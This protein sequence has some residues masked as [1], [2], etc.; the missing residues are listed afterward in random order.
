M[1]MSMCF[2]KGNFRFLQ[3]VGILNGILGVHVSFLMCYEI[4]ISAIFTKKNLPRGEDLKNEKKT[5]CKGYI[6]DHTT[7][8]YGIM[9]NHCKLWGSLSNNQY[10]G[11]QYVFC[12]W[13]M[14]FSRNHSTP[15][16]IY[17]ERH[18]LL[19]NHTKNPQED[20]RACC[21]LPRNS[22]PKNDNRTFLL[23]TC[24]NSTF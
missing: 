22:R 4:Y 21:M 18:Q 1:L 7:Q 11:K 12:C 13:L 19:Q 2:F 15:C 20:I 14:C 10:H 16:K 17:I 6:G 3:S 23:S 5:G 24:L 9:I 8:L